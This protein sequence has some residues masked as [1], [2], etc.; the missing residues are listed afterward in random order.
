MVAKASSNANALQDAELEHLLDSVGIRG[1]LE[2]QAY[3][4]GWKLRLVSY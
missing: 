3:R 4:D 2:D 1:K